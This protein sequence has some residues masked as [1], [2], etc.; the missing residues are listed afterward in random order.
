[1]VKAKGRSG[2]KRKG[3]RQSENFKNSNVY[4]PYVRGIIW[5]HESGR[6]EPIR[7]G[8]FDFS[9]ADCVIGSFGYRERNVR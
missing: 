7:G 9:V 4:R 5:I 2:R 6:R 1:M 8:N 3:S